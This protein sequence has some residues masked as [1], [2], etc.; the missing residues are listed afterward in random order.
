MNISNSNPKVFDTFSQADLTVHH[1]QAG[2]DPFDT[3]QVVVWCR[4]PAL[5]GFFELQQRADHRTLVSGPMKYF[6]VNAWGWHE[7]IAD[8]T[9]FQEPGLYRLWVTTGSGYMAHTD[10]FRIV[11]NLHEKL[12]HKATAHIHR[13]RCGVLC[14]PHDAWIRS[15]EQDTFGERI[16][17][18]DVSGGWH[19]ACDDSKWVIISAMPCIDALVDTWRSLRPSWKGTGETLSFPLAEAYWEVQW[20]LKMLKPDG[21]F[22]Y[23]VLDWKKQWN[24]R[25][26]RWCLTPWAYDGFHEY[27]VL[28]DD[29]RWLIDEWGSGKI[30][31]LL[32]IQNLCPS[33]P[34]MYHALAAATL[35]RFAEAI[36]EF[37]A[38]IADQCH[39]AGKRILAW[40]EGRPI[41]PFQFIY[42]RAA[43][44]R[45]HLSLAR[46]E[47]NE[48]HLSVAE[49][50][51]EEVLALQQPSGWFAAAEGFACC[52]MQPQ[53]SEDRVA[54]DYPFNY[55]TALLCYLEECPQGRLAPIVQEALTSFFQFSKSLM[56][57]SGAF[58]HLPEYV[59]GRIPNPLL[60]TSSHG[61]NS[62]F[63]VTAYLMAWGSR[64][65][66]DPSLGRLAQRQVQWVL[67]ANPRG[68]SFMIGIGSRR[69][70][71]QPLFVHADRRDV[72]WGITNGIYLPGGAA[73]F[74]GGHGATVTDPEFVNAGLSEE[75]GYDAAAEEPWLTPTGWFLAANAQLAKLQQTL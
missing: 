58:E 15:T 63:L 31:T 75:G 30:N 22:Y 36:R 69:A 41:A 46:I 42:T 49:T 40:L 50:Y 39:A 52:E 11:S 3:K 25:L 32:G 48:E 59:E 10:D 73:D 37:D 16:R 26:Q 4:R 28:E 23:A 64:L 33:T 12:A 13:K 43:L 1:C 34:E 14:H 61:Y 55:I 21:S 47:R 65:L 74:T 8:L 6:G 24:A 7:W 70:A 56:S 19:D 38:L 53:Q 68:M 9:A 20:L 60:T 54:T 71:L 44:A 5:T 35:L 67:G 57:K 66:S 51:I 62:W 2:Y 18:V 17:H 72:L 29:D 45:A 27:D